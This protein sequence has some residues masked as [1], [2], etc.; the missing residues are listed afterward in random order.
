MYIVARTSKVGSRLCGIDVN[1]QLQHW[2]M[3]R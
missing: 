3:Y 2:V 1:K